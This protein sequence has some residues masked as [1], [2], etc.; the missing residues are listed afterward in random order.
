VPD[1]VEQYSGK[2]KYD[3]AFAESSARVSRLHGPMTIFIMSKSERILRRELDSTSNLMS[4]FH[5]IFIKD[6]I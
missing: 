3:A 6:A 5:L 1:R 4:C 2:R